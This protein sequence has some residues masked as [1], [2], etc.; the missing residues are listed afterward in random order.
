MDDQPTTG[1]L[2]LVLVLD[3][4]IE[5]EIEIEGMT[6]KAIQQRLRPPFHFPV[7][8]LQ[9]RCLPTKRRRERREWYEYGYGYGPYGWRL[10]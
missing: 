9:R 1:V 4:E 8:S 10:Q 5:I 7:E 6:I 2:V 3:L